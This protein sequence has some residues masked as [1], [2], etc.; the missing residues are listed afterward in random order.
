VLKVLVVGPE[1]LSGVLGPTVLGRPDIDHVHVESP[2]GAVEA[3]ASARPQM[4]V[5]DLPPGE[6]VALV[7][8]LRDNSA[9]RP[10]A[11]VWLDRGEP[12]EA[13]TEIAVAGANAVVTLPLDPFLWDR[14]LEELLSVPTRRTRRI[15]VRLRDWASF[16]VDAG[17]QHGT[18]I[19]IGVRGVLLESPRQLDLGAKVGLTLELPGEPAPVAVVGQVVR[20]AGE[21]GGQYRAGIEFLVYRGDARDRIARFVESEPEDSDRRGAPAAALPL[22][23]RSFEGQEEWED[24]LRASEIR[25]ALILDSA[26]DCILTT[27]HEGRVIEFNAAARRVFGYTRSE[28]LGREVADTIVPP[29][30]RD[31]LRRRLSDFVLTGEN[32]DLGRRREATAMRADGS[33]LPVEVVVVPAYVKGRVILTAYIRDLTERRRGERLAVARQRATQALTAALSLAE[34]TPTVLEALVQGLECADARLWVADGDPPEPTLAGTSPGARMAPLPASAVDSLVRRTFEDGEAAW[35]DAGGEA[36]A[37]LAVPV[38]VGGQVLGVLEV[39]WDKARARD[40]DLVPAV[41]DVASL[42]ALFLKRQSAEAD[43]HRFARYDSLTGLPN[44]S[45]FL[46]TLERTLSRAGRQRTRSALLFLDLDGFKSVNDALGHAAGDA[47]LQ[48]M[49]DRLRGGTR[50]SDVVARIGGDEFTVLVQ[51]LTRADDAALV[52]RGLLDRLARPCQ[53]DDHEVA[54]SASAGISVYPDDGTDADTLLRNADLAMYRAK[55]DGKNTYRFFT[56]EMSERALERM[57]LLDSLR[58]AL[59]RDEFEIVYLPVVHRE[60][61]PS[62]EALLRWRHPKLGVVTPA[63]FIA[64]A[65][66]SGLILPIGAGVLRGATR[67]AAS[68]E[69]KDVRVVVNL[70]ARQFL[71]PNLV[72][73][74]AEALE[75]S[76]LPAC[77]LELDLTEPTVMTEGEETTTRLR[78]LRELGV[79]LALDDFGTGYF[80]IRRIR[81]LGFRRLKIDRSLVSGLP[82]N[83]EQGAHVVAILGLGRSLGLEVVAEG[84]ENEAQRAFLEAHDCT[85]LQGYL[86]SPPLTADEV[87]GFLAK[88]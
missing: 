51:N 52:V 55:Q 60:G 4:V 18:I 69:R 45:F 34:A 70:S 67:F 71:Q 15:P 13:E 81:D 29:R 54:L 31:E 11:I 32:S 27:D 85:G 40:A 62:L 88:V 41:A 5:I 10:T 83:P 75:K 22:S 65:E 33:F 49:A 39:R 12:G 30:L 68:L 17:E 6:A 38:R 50:T 77:R 21:E 59:E 46:D 56:A 9:T 1:S 64:Q 8:S 48:A 28:I 76:G 35:T 61:P 79:Q 14:R 37:T 87:P 80:S 16:V 43:L 44:R 42:L 36:G 53:A 3:A 2:Q 84:V 58:V 23:V 24:E 66:E 7:R 25:K 20:L 47:V 82:D 57:L 86:L 72:G 73:T 26:L 63:S 74:V 78:Q 19:N